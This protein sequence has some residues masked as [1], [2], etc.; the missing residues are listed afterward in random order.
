MPELI[1]APKTSR[2]LEDLQKILREEAPP[3]PIARL[4][5]FRIAHIEL[6]RSLFEMDAG[7]H[8]ANPMGTMHGGVVCDLADIAM[9]TAMATSL[10]DEESFTTID[11]TAKYFKPVWTARL[12]ASGTL[13]KRTRALG[14]IEC[15]IRDEAES[16]VAKVFSTCMVLRG[17]EAKGR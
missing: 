7:P 17:Q 6:G 10:E 5:G 1:R 12:R 8:L 4:L 14:F 9:G 11:L 2:H 13:V 15:E 16:L 3:P